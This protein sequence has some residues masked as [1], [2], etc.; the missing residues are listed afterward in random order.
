M[1]NKHAILA[2]SASKRWMACP[3]SARLCA[4]LP[5]KSSSY[6]LQGTDAHELAAYKVLHAI[7]EDVKDPTENLTFFD[8]EMDSYTDA[9][10]D[11]VMEKYMDAKKH[12]KDPVLLVEQKLDFSEWV[13]EGYGTG[14]AVIVAD[15]ILHVIDLKFGMGV[16]VNAEENPQLMC[17]GLGALSLFDGIY[18]IQSVRL[19]IFQPRRDNIST[20]E[21]S[22]E[23]L[24][25]WAKDT[26]SPA[27]ELAF[28][29]EGEFHAGDHCQFCKLKATCRKR[30]E[31]NLEMARY[32]FEMPAKLEDIEI[33]GLLGK[34]DKLI[35]W[36]NDIKE[37]AL[38][39]AVKG[40][41]WNGY[42]LVEGR[43][44]RKYTDEKTVADKVTNAGYDPYEKKVLGITAMTKLL[45][46][47]KFEELLGGLVEKPQG[48][49]TLVSQS[50]AR[51]EMNLSANAAED[52]KEDN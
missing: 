25:R 42:K 46:K 24:L 31:Y 19:S 33:E 15:D 36:A 20:Y 23:D 9:Y 32:D 26:L 7:G 8:Q 51:P 16:I 43:S 3:P 34:L 2:A 48:K 52:F 41:K 45:G 18:D 12:C 37:Y 21:I 10:R 5:D 14:D 30:A 17:Y 22:K 47:K 4:E 44:N 40:K 29:G 27:A 28:K 6:A 35:A 1:A 11:F 49:P 38:D 50:D 39:E 13:P